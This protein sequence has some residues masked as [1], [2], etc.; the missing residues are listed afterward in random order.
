MIFKVV[1]KIYLIFGHLKQ[2]SKLLHKCP[3]KLSNEQKKII[4]NSKR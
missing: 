3:T 1:I 2:K 4:T